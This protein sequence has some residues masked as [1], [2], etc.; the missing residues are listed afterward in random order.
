MLRS[1]NSV[2]AVLHLT[3]NLTM[4]KNDVFV[5]QRPNFP[6]LKNRFFFVSLFMA[7]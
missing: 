5:Q 7:L 6:K 1:V 3:S 2:Q 4:F